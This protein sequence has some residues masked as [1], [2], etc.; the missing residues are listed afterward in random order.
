MQHQL[1]FDVSQAPDKDS[2][3]SRLVRFG[4]AMDFGL[5]NAWL[6]VERPQQ[7]A[8][9]I[10]TGNRP[11][12]FQSSSSD[13]ELVKRDP[14]LGRLRKESLPFVYDQDLYTRS[15]AGDIWELSA[16]FGYRTGVTVALHLPENRH[17]VLSL[18]REQPLPR[19]DEQ[20]ARMLADL[21]LLAVHSQDAA[22]RLL[23]PPSTAPRLNITHDERALLAARA[24]EGALPQTA[25]PTSGDLPAIHL[26]PREREVLQ[27]AM[28]N[29]SGSVTAQIMGISHAAV[30]FHLSN[31]MKKLNAPTKHAAVFRAVAK[32][33]IS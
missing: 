5:V 9:V 1:F 20:I 31:A 24:Q 12:D 6:V 4:H 2:F 14:V 13:P 10:Y 27:W 32:G 7:Q 16:S 15:G 21:Q 18:S 11:Q 19:D 26:T 25:S 33:L 8:D 30:K 17:F 22:L 3:E 23:S 29:K 28:E